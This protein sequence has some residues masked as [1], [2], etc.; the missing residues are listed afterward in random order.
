MFERCDK[1]SEQTVAAAHRRK[2][3]WQTEPQ[4]HCS[5]VGTCLTLADL[6]RI[7]TKLGI[8]IPPN[9]ED[10]DIHGHFASAVGN[11]G[12]VAKAMNKTLDRAHAAAIRR[13]GRVKGE[14]ELR[15][16]WARC[17]EDG[18]IPGPYWALLTHPC[19]TRNLISHAF[20]HVHMLSH[21]VGASNRA[22]IR[23]LRDLENER[24]VLA[25]D[26]GKAKRRITEGDVDTRRLVDQHAEEVREFGVRLCA[27]KT[28][29]R[30]L[31]VAEQRIQHLKN[32]ETLRSARRRIH[33]LECQLATVVAERE[34]AANRAAALSR[35]LAEFAGT[36][37]YLEGALHA[38]RGEC[39]ALEAMLCA[40]LGDSGARTRSVMDLCGRRIVYVGGRTGLVPHLRALVQRS[41]GT[42][43]H[44]DGGVEEKGD[45]LS[46]VV[47]QG[48]AVLCPVDCVSHGACRLA[49]R[50]CK[51]RSKT[52]VPLRSSGVSC[53]V[54]GL[55]EIAST[56]EPTD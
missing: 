51:Q 3:L 9:F 22:D 17:L 29:E 28:T 44:H 23:R 53:F 30:R 48:D 16:L 31:T 37:E 7:A 39:E 47:A 2:K 54:S 27:A 35:E 32:G 13:F 15:A 25:E 56:M 45:R 41:N 5:I 38:T 1:P 55:R 10:Y 14:D 49:K 40:G 50:V 20:G 24:A 11:A 18:D 26:L 8:N 34:G 21:L 19:S 42:F 33:E 36:N 43:L 4:L 12:P 52:F 6:R 46:E